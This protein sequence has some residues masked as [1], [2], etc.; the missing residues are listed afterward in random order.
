MKNIDIYFISFVKFLKIA[1]T[2]QN[3]LDNYDM[4]NELDENLPDEFLELC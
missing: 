4:I 1:V 2:L 3:A